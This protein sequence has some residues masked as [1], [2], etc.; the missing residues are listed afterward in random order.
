MKDKR[1][2]IY[3]TMNREKEEFI[4]LI[5]EW[6]KDF[7][8][9][10]SCW[11][12]VYRNPHIWNMRA[13]A[14]WDLLRNVIK[15]I[16][17]YPVKH[18]MNLTDVWHLTDDGDEWEDK[19]E[20]WAKRENKTVWELADMYIEKFY[21][22]LDKLQIEKF[23]VMPRATEH[24][25]E[26]IE[27]IKTLE[28]KWY[29]YEIQ[30]DWIYMD[31]NKVEDYWKLAWLENQER[32]A[33][34]RI[35]NNNK[36]NSTDFALWKFSPKN[37]KRQMERDSPRWT[38]FPWWHIECSAMSSKYLWDQF[39]IHTWGVDHIWVHH[40]NEIAQS[41]CTFWKKPWVKY[42]MHNQFLNLWW[43]KLS[44]STWGLITVDD[45][46]EKWY[47]WLDLKMLYYTAHYRN[48]LDFNET[49]L[50]QSKVQRKNIIKKIN[51]LEKQELRWKNYKEV[52]NEI[53]TKEW[54]KFLSDC[55]DCLLDDLNTPKLLATIN[56]GLKNPNPE[57]V[58]IIV[59]LDNQV[60]KLDLIW[61]KENI[62]QNYHEIPKIITDLANQRLLAKQE[63]NYQLADELRSQIQ[64]HWYNIKDIPW[65]FEI[66]KL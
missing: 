1:L 57:I 4:P 53:K 28:K 49:V 52:S 7:V 48:F 40:T 30:D 17:W 34:A 25:Q 9:I 10:Y 58:W 60:L 61:E 54:T 24:I 21:N 44:K 38:W 13:F 6:K 43:K 41:E 45:L 31:T 29:T 3:N 27:M 23:D 39:D 65:W 12:T 22:Y 11:P 5:D 18:V 26:Q 33:W 46:E 66:E 19:M 50:E 64:S 59:W 2:Y 51:K 42:R 32:I 14:F 56:S 15:N 36:K 62:N 63:K 16:L 55:L 35:Q 20:K 8:W 37:Q 47:S